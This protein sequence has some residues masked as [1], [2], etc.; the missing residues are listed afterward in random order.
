MIARSAIS[1]QIYQFKI[2]LID[3]QP[4]IWRRIQVLNSPLNNLHECIQIAMGWTNSHLHRFEIDEKYFGIPELLDDGFGNFKG[5]DSRAIQ[6]SE[7]IP[8]KS[9]AF[10]F[11]Y[12][13]DFG[14]AWRHEIVSE[15]FSQAEEHQQYPLCLDGERA[16]PP[17]DVGGIWGYEEFLEIMADPEHEEHNQYKDWLGPFAPE[18]FDAFNATA[19]LQHGLPNLE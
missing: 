15:E 3:S 11:L 5:V 17:E 1:D 12:L 18:K 7:I 10:R 19:S 14:D 6:L 2:I 13:Y 8:Q 16:C 9:K 4:S